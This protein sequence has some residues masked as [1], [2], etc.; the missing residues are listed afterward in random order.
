MFS[1]IQY[2]KFTR[3]K[4]I[5]L[6]IM[7]LLDRDQIKTVVFHSLETIADLPQNPEASNFS[8]LDNFHKHVF[9]STLKGKI[10]SLPYFMNDGTTTYMAY[11]DIA[12]NP[13]S[14]DD[15]GTVK[16]CID[17]IEENQR[18]IYL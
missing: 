5:K 9:L 4:P 7:A 8:S 2:F 3:S 17:W 6:I 13:D 1:G 11:Y 15:W 16:A 18:V 14:T 12:I 10:N